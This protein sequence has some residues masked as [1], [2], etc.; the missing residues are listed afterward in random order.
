MFRD[1]NGRMRKLFPGVG[2]AMLEYSADSRQRLLA[3]TIRDKR[4]VYMLL[5]EAPFRGMISDVADRKYAEGDIALK[6]DYR[7]AEPPGFQI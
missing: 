5:P 3:K 1:L 4:G 2:H 7:L 6:A